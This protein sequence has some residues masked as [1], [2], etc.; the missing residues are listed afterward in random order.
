MMII[1]YQRVKVNV[2]G[3]FFHAPLARHVDDKM[4][5]YKSTF[6]LLILR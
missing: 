4:P 6:Y 5:V 1:N 2:Q 3:H